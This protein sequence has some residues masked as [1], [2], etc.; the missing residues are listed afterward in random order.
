MGA[1]CLGMACA[2]SALA[3]EAPA[4]AVSEGQGSPLVEV[5][6]GGYAEA[7]FGYAALTTP[8]ASQKIATGTV[9]DLDMGYDLSR[10]L[11]VGLFVWGAALSTPSSSSAGDFSAVFPGA[12]LRLYLPLGEDAAGTQRLVLGLRAG[13]GLMLF[14]PGSA[15]PGPAPAARAGVDLEYFTRLRHFSVGIGAEGVAAFPSGGS[16][17]GAALS[18]F[19]RYSF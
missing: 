11:G 5:V 13:G 6:R 4:A 14:S 15:A 17:F 12:E 18:P 1:L 8:G 9:V 7:E 3:A 10:A 19:A 16:L 2:A